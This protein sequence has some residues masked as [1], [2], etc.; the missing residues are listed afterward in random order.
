MK[1]IVPEFRTGKKIAI[2][3]SGPSGLAAAHQLNR[4]GHWVTVYER[5]DSIGGLLRYGIP[6]MKLSRDVKFLP[7]NCM[8]KCLLTFSVFIF[9]QVLQRRIDL[10]SA[11]GIEFC[12]NMEIGK[13]MRT[14]DLVDM[15][16]AVLMTTGATWPR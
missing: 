3:G 12:T 5:N 10:M 6:T 8:Q 9:H 14:N 7:A 16:D 2:V 13:K 1:P 11:E 15:Y 4:A